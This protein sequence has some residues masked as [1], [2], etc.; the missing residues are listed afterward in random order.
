MNVLDAEERN[1]TNDEIMECVSP[2][3]PE[4]AR[5]NLPELLGAARASPDN[6][7]RE[8]VASLLERDFELSFL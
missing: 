3:Y 2:R 1:A 4:G 5:D 7:Q 6:N 8:F